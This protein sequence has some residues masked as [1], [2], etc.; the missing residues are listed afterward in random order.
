MKRFSSFLWQYHISEG[1]VCGS[2]A[3][4]NVSIASHGLSWIMIFLIETHSLFRVSGMCLWKEIASLGGYLLLDSLGLCFTSLQRQC[5]LGAH[6][7]I[8]PMNTCVLGARIQ[9]AHQLSIKSQ[10]RFMPRLWSMWSKGTIFVGVLGLPE[11]LTYLK[12]F[13]IYS[14]FTWSP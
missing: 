13:C 4:I 8:P 6:D 12:H 10:L 14:Y 3:R 11:E 5:L 2:L 9:N 7:W 1:E